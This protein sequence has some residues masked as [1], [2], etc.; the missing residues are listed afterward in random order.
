MRI[1]EFQ[2]TK[3][4]L[5]Q[6]PNIIFV[7]GDNTQRI[8]KGGAAVLRDH[9]RSY[10]FI[11]KRNPGMEDE[12]FF[13]TKEYRTV[14]YNEMDKLHNRIR[15]NP[16]KLFYISRLGAGLANRFGIWEKIIMPA[17][18]AQTKCY[19]NVYLLWD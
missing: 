5:N 12:D 11:T 8:G 17:I 16:D 15:K 6:N 14:F 13:T 2:V 3:E 19:K 1:K 10:G 4:T 9:P 18:D 7:F